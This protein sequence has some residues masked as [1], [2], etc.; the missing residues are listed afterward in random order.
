M[1][2][3]AALAGYLTGAW[4]VYVDYQEYCPQRRIPLPGSEY[5]RLLH[6]PLEVFGDSEWQKIR[7]ALNRG[8]FEEASHLA[9]QLADRLYDYSPGRG[10]E[11]S[12]PG[13]R[14]LV[15]L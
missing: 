11:P 13:F 12:G 8:G 15:S 1:S 2:A 6:N 10:L 9:G 3:S 5:P 7:A 14:G 4:L